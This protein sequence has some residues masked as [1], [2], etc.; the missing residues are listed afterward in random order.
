M[1]GHLRKKTQVST[2]FN[3]G[4]TNVTLTLRMWPMSASEGKRKEAMVTRMV[5]WRDGELIR[6]Y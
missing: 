6:D 4:A 5:R 1:H 2:G 3:G